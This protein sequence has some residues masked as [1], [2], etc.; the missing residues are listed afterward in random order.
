MVVISK[1]SHLI[2]TRRLA[3]IS[4]HKAGDVDI[5]SQANLSLGQSMRRHLTRQA[6]M[7]QSQ[8]IKSSKTKQMRDASGDSQGGVISVEA[9]TVF[10]S[11]CD[12]SQPMAEVGGSHSNRFASSRRQIDANGEQ[13]AA[14][15]VLRRFTAENAHITQ[16]YYDSFVGRWPNLPAIENAAAPC[17]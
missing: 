2:V 1:F 7:L 8:P 5:M 13:Q 17:E 11:S 10:I 12:A 6:V 15:Y 3:D 16:D 14:L 9:Q 4:A